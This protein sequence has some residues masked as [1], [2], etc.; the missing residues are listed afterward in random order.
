MEIKITISDGLIRIVKRAFNRR[1]GPF[2]LGVLIFGMIV[3]LSAD[4][5]VIPYEFESG[6]V[7]SSAQMNDNFS[8]IASR[9][10]ALQTQV[11]ALVSS[12]GTV[13]DTDSPYIYYNGGNV[14]IGTAAPA[15]KLHVAGNIQVTGTVYA[16]WMMSDVYT[17]KMSNGTGSLDTGVSAST[18]EAFIGGISD[19]SNVGHARHRYWIYESGGKWRLYVNYEDSAALNIKIRVLFIRSEMFSSVDHQ[20]Y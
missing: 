14:G 4:T 7:I 5:F 3:G 2:I 17:V 10:N 19:Q 8:Q 18:W 9:I 13:W 11:D 6:E 12:S 15:Q 1:T 16:P 20:G